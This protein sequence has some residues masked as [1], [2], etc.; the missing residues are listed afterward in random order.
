MTA[1]TPIACTLAGLA[2]RERERTLL[3]D[4]RAH[5]RRV[6]ERPDGYALELA[7]GDEA[8]ATAAAVIRLERRCCPFLR[9]T[10]TVEPNDGVI[11]LAL[12]GGPGVREF[13]STWL[14][15]DTDATASG[16]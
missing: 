1:G 7:T 15:S 9:F 5:T 16:R 4:L 14:A 2:L 12:T 8:L 11:S 10:L 3:A 6:S 13:L